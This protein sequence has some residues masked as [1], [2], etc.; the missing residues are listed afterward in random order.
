MSRHSFFRQSGWMMIASIAGGGFMWAVHLVMQKPVDQLPI[1]P[2]RDF[3][4]RFIQAPPSEAQ[5]GLFATLLNLVMWMSIPSNGLQTVFAQQAA[6]SS[7]DQRERQLRGTV[8]SVLSATTLIWGVLTVLFFLS[9]N[10][11][12]AGLNV[13]DPMALWLTVF[14][15]LPILWTP[16][17]AGLLQ[18]R[19]NFLWLGWTSMMSGLGRCLA[20]LVLVRMLGGGV[21]GAMAAVLIGSAVPLLFSLWQT[22]GDWHGPRIPVQW[23]PWLRRLVP[24]TVG[25]GVT[26]VMLS[27]DMIVVRRFFPPTETGFYAAAAT[28]GRALFLFTVPLAGV[29]FPKIVRS[30]ALAERTD[31]L[32]QALGA[33]AIMGAGAALFLTIFPKLPLQI[34]YGP[35]YLVIAPLVPWYMWCVLPVTLAN[36]L[37]NNLLARERFG[38]VPWILLVAVAYVATLWIVGRGLSQRPPLESFRTIVQLLGG[39][40]FLLLLTSIWFTW[41]KK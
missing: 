13:P 28:L 21:T 26:I 12:L 11:I 38:I 24:L 29:M 7:D 9:R 22:R 16:I 25:L 32:A 27:V 41:R 23:G 2:I 15:G 14:V 3:L 33:T 10:R 34:V 5:Y 39:F 30:A 8:R 31:V 4:A 19:Q 35:S 40:N 18:G 37:I 6:A 1:V 20:A 17:F 36:I